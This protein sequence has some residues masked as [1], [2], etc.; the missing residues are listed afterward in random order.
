MNQQ[1]FN[2]TGLKP[3]AH[4]LTVTNQGGAT[5]APLGVS[6]IYTKVT[7]TGSTSGG[8][9]GGGSG[10]SSGGGGRRRGAGRYLIPILGALIGALLL[11]TLALWCLRRF[12]RKREATGAPTA[13]QTPWGIGKNTEAQASLLQTQG[14][15]QVP[16]TLYNAPPSPPPPNPSVW[17]QP[18]Y[19]PYTNSGFAPQVNQGQVPYQ[20]GY[21][22]YAGGYNQNQF[23]VV[24]QGPRDQGHPHAAT[25]PMQTM[26]GMRDGGEFNPYRRT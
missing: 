1:F 7:G 8:G 21:R 23:Y 26:D 14:K 24:P 12:K 6:Y 19:V 11:L 15:E 18:Q 5:S 2:V 9:G 25:I 13:P 17:Q 10:G 22:P 3:G 20:Q 4:R 16:N